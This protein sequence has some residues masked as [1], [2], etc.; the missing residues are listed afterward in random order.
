MISLTLFLKAN[1][2]KKL[3][4]VKKILRSY[5]ENLNVETRIL[6]IQNAGWFQLSIKGEDKKIAA[7]ILTNKIGLCPKNID[8]IKTNS[9]LNGRIS[10]FHENKQISIDIGIF[11]PNV[12]HATLS[13]ERLNDQL[14][15]NNKL[16][17]KQIST[18]FGLTKEL[19]TEIKIIGINKEKK[20]IQTELSKNQ[21]SLFESWK[22]SLQDRLIIIGATRSK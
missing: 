19:P 2:K 11:E 8:N 10:E 20:F 21:L 14:L 1:N 16:N 15:L 13:L 12:I 3:N 6:Q 5:L 7:S 18:F 22:K 9:I 4:Q 17:L